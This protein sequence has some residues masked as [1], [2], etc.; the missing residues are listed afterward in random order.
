[1]ASETNI[2]WCDKTFNPWTGCTKVSPG[3]ANCYAETWAK[4]T[5]TVK[6]GAG[7]PRRRTKTWGDPMKWNREVLQY[8][9]PI[10]RPRVFCASLADW[11]DHE[12][13][14]AWLL[15]LIVLIRETPNLD[16]LLLTKRPE[17]FFPRLME[18][19]TMA[20]TVSH[21]GITAQYIQDWI[22]GDAPKNIWIGTTAENQEQA[23]KRIPALLKIPARVR[24]LSCEPL[25]GP[26]CIPDAFPQTGIESLPLGEGQ[27]A[28]QWVI[29]KQWGEHNEHGKK[30]GKAKAGH[31]LDGQTYQAFPI[32]GADY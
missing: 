28:I 18:A 15:D 20:V 1:M 14:T 10:V 16:W 32:E 4:R 21:D 13:P 26:V 11:L 3:C 23:N 12:V 2:S 29:F 24:F 7:Q 9:K 27:K 30:V 25:L 31:Q 22:D 8:Q 5:G 6:W 19:L 17:N